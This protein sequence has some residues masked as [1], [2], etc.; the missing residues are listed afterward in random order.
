MS[1]SSRRDFLRAT[2]A[3][4]T[5]A[6]LPPPTTPCEVA[7]LGESD[8]LAIPPHRP[9]FLEG[10]HAYTDKVS[11]ACGDTIGF[12]VSSTHAY[13]LQ[14]CRLG[15]EV[16]DPASDLVLH[17]FQQASPAVQPIHPGSYV[18]IENGLPSDLELEALSLELW[19]RRWRTR[20]RQA[21]LA[22]YDEPD[23]CG[24]GLFVN[25]DG[26]VGAYLGDGRAYREQSHYDSPPGV[27]RLTINPLGLKEYP[28]NSPS[29]VQANQWQHIV[30]TCRAGQAELW[31]D[32]HHL[33][34]WKVAG[35]VRAGTAPLRF[36]AAGRAGRADFLL[37]ADIAMP[38]LYGR[39]L[40][41]AEIRQRFEQK[42]RAPAGGQSVLAC[43]RLAEERG[44]RVADCSGHGRDGRLVNHGTWMIGGPS[45]QADVPRFGRY[46]PR[47]DPDRGHGLRLASDDLYSCRWT[48]T[49]VLRIPSSARPGIYA[50][51]IRFALDGEHRLYHTLFLVRRSAQ[52]P[53]PPILFLCST[54][55]WRAYAATP[56]S[57]TWP[58]L[59]KSIG[60]NGFANSPGDPPPPAFCL[61]RPHHAGQGTYH[62][63]CRMPWPVAGPYTLIGPEAWDNSHLCRA[64]RFTQVWLEREGYDYDVLSDT[65]LHREPAIL[66]GSKVLFIVGHSEYWSFEAM[67]AVDR[68]LRRGGSV[69]VLSGNTA[70]WR[71]S[72]S[73]DGSTLECRKADAPGSQVRADRRGEIWHSDDGGRGGMAREC[74][75]PAWSLLGLE[76]MSLLGVGAKGAGP[77]RVRNPDH[78]LF[79]RPIDLGLKNGDTFGGARGTT[80]PQPIGHEADV[81]V[82]TL[83]RFLVEPAPAG[84]TSPSTDPPGVTLL[85]EGIADWRTITQGAPY[86]YFQRAVPSERC[87]QVPVAGEMIYWERPSGGR[88]FHA[89]SINAGWTLAR[90][91]PWSGL[92]KNV[93]HHFGVPVE[94][95]TT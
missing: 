46:D 22:Q 34:T 88:V 72:Y 62:V 44:S 37:D 39:F 9:L 42:G 54:N 78:F 26:A 15:L 36:G 91:P 57:P 64:E 35:A 82:S 92:L 6:A 58:G 11:V 65:D 53:A 24:F 4:V 79:R 7:P 50:A 69:V 61:Y 20:G 31:V 23:S 10:V 89:G 28:D 70:F 40:G 18:H 77:Y 33:G 73:E 83:S 86:D 60:N 84:G 16:D 51:R 17:S 87:P 13:E 8:D 93:L 56:F 12:H 2:G 5:A 30:V 19:V 75:Y 85:A 38:A 41:S 63:G 67:T 68:F 71:V 48:P 90:D 1:R 80:L 55:T 14:V 95:A 25:E 21:L 52:A 74:G 94:K 66:D 32:A 43:W 59:K 45:F 47:S 3:A 81:R 49:H 27:L 76:Y 29:V